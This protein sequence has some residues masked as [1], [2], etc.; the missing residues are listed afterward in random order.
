MQTAWANTALQSKGWLQGR[1]TG[2]MAVWTPD[3]GKGTA[4]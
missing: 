1:L 2:E 3:K 4:P